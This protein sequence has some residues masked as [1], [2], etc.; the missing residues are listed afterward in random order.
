MKRVL[1]IPVVALT[2][3]ALVGAFAVAGC[4]APPT[5]PA[6]A[7]LPLDEA[8]RALA[9]HLLTQLRAKQSTFSALSE[10]TIAVEPLVD[11]QTAE[12]TVASRHIEQLLGDEA[13]RQFPR[14]K[15]VPLN[16]ESVETAAYVLTGM[17]ALDAKKPAADQSQYR[18]TAS[19]TDLRSNVVVA[20]G[21]AP[22][23]DRNLDVT[24]VRSHQDNPMY[25]KDTRTEALIKTAQAAPGAQAEK[26]YMDSLTTA[27]LLAEGDR[28]YDEKSYDGA[29]RYYKEASLRPDGQLMRTYAALYQAQ[30]KLGRMDEAEVAFGRLV[31]IGA[32]TDN[33]SAKI[34]FSVGSLQFIADADLREQYRL[35][36]RQIAK[37]FAKAARCL[38]IVGHSS[39]TGNEAFN[40]NLSLQRAQAVQKLMQA[41]FPAIAERSSTLGRG[42]KDNIVGTGSDDLRDA[43]DRR[44]EFRIVSCKP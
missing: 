32:R 17:V 10:A 22:I 19:I 11:A 34:M 18:V 1:T 33:L 44:V 38:S 21:E 26:E 36:L 24:P 9:N 27:A 15:L 28:R 7:A 31:A 6:T 30:R 13:R 25:T 3:L 40:E 2:V 41:D 5:K 29:L 39:R 37:H 4:A 12:V 20:S 35:W 23:A 16:P 14:L 8:A 43:I 42:W